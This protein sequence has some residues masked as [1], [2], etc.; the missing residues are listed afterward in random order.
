MS[1]ALFSKNWTQLITLN[2][3]CNELTGKV[4]STIG[5]LSKLESLNLSFNLLTG[6][7]P[8]NISLLPNSRP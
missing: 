6:E 3:S 1:P 7:V 5:L 2:L 8:S 4:P